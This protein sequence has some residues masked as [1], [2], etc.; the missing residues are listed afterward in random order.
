[1]AALATAGVQASDTDDAQ[2]VELRQYQLEPGTRDAFV[3]LF[4][5]KLVDGQEAA[6]MRL[7]GQFRDRDDGDRFTW[8]RAFADMPAR[9]HALNSFYFGPVWKANRAAANPMLI[10]NDNVLLLRPAAPGL[11]FGPAPARD[12]DAPAGA[13]WVIIEYLWKRPD[14][15]FV[16]LFRDRMQPALEA[17]GVDV[18]GA[19]VPVDEP[20]G[21]P[22]LPVREERKLFVWLVRGESHE[23]LAEKLD[24]ARNSERWQGDIAAPLR[25]AEERAPQILHLDPTPRSAQR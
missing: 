22:Q 1:M 3:S 2:V 18:L 20:N 21:F 19:F 6:G 17:A 8:V 9:E 15:G 24:R 25:A 16:D 10:D 14:A 7:V 11:G 5:D 13:I 12:P 4:E 23:S